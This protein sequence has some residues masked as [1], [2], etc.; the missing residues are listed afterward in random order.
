MNFRKS[1]VAFVPAMALLA[2]AATARAANTDSYTLDGSGNITVDNAA[3]TATFTAKPIYIT[4][5]TALEPVLK[6]VGPALTTAP[7]P[8]VIVYDKSLGSCG[9]AALVANPP[10]PI[11]STTTMYYVPAGGDGTVNATCTQP[12]TPVS[13]P[14]T[15]VLSDVDISLCPGSPA[16]PTTAHDFNGP[17][18]DMV[19]VVPASSTQKAISA[20]DVYLMFGMGAS[21]MVS[22]WVDPTAYFTRSNTSGTRAMIAINSGLGAHDWQGMPQ[23][24]SGPVFNAV[25]A[26]N[27]T[28]AEKTIGILGEDFYDASTG[29]VSN[30]NSVKALAFRGFH[31]QLAYWPD[32]TLTSRDRRNVR[33]GRYAIWG[34][35]HTLANVDGT[36]TPTDA[37]AKY[38]IDLLSGNL[39]SPPVDVLSLTVS[40]H[41]T[42]VCAMNVTHAKE[43]APMTPYT[44]AAPC[45]C[46]FDTKVAGTAPAS[47]MA[48]TMDS[49]CTSSSATHCRFGYCEAH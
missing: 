32:S 19:L 35:V 33:D 30:R 17:V 14:Y 22:P 13:P 44:P 7:T 38:F 47:C 37:G 20:E 40:S 18:N 23:T 49:D 9:G 46:A 48:C 24:G 27:Q 26:N 16:V 2:G 41:L 43:G 34:Y 36:G 11:A 25:V 3:G 39:A 12:A 10:M 29:G 8:Y 31:Q 4:G 1:L 45:G 21:G 5:S 6:A 42:P 15:L 28:A